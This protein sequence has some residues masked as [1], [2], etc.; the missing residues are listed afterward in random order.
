[1]NIFINLYLLIE[2]LNIIIIPLYLTILKFYYNIKI[3]NSVLYSIIIFLSG[4]YIYTY[5]SFTKIKEVGIAGIILHIYLLGLLILYTI[6]LFN[7]LFRNDFKFK[8]YSR[9]EENISILIL[10]SLFS[11]LLIFILPILIS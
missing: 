2:L 5:Y 9:N 3:I 10:V 11:T 7:I 8:N 4:T 6:Y 1:M